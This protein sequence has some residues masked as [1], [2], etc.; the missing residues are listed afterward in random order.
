V[1]NTG[2]KK[3][4]TG[5]D[6]V[7]IVL[8]L[9][10]K[11][12]TYRM[13]AIIIAALILPIFIKEIDEDLLKVFDDLS[14]YTDKFYYGRYDIKTT[15]IED[16]KQGKNFLVLEFMVV[17]RAQSHLRLWYEHLASIR[18]YYCTTGKCSIK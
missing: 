1:P 9:K 5:M 6:I 10:E 4:S 13:P 12:F 2:W 8:F 14:H 11:F 3:W 7:S 17:A 18:G 15:S 16:L